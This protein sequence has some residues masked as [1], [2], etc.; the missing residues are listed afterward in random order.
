MKNIELF[1]FSLPSLWVCYLMLCLINDKKYNLWRCTT[2]S[3]RGWSYLFFL[4]AAI[5]TWVG[6]LKYGQL[7]H[8]DKLMMDFA[9][10]LYFGQRAY[11]VH[12]LKQKHHKKG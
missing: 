12:K 1:V 11:R 7:P 4:G 9:A 5:C 6:V 8:W 10:V 2:L 3:I